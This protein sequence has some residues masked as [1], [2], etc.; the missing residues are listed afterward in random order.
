MKEIKIP[1]TKKVVEVQE[2]TRYLT[3]DGRLFDTLEQAQ[4]HEHILNETARHADGRYTHDHAMRVDFRDLPTDTYF[5]K[6]GDDRN[7][8]NLVYYLKNRGYDFDTPSLPKEGI[9]AGVWYAIESGYD[10]GNDIYYVNIWKPD[11]IIEEME[12]IVSILKK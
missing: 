11:L 2:T 5:I 8:E 10:G 1:A 9:E 3:D 4:I 12:R 6:Y 7:M